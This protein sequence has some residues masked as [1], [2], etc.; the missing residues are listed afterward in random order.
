[1]SGEGVAF[2]PIQIFEYA[3]RGD[4]ASLREVL[5]PEEQPD[6]RWTTRSGDI[7]LKNKDN[8]T[9][10]HVACANGKEE[11]ANTLIQWGADFDA[12]NNIQ[13]TPLLLATM[14]NLTSTVQCLLAADADPNTQDTSG[15]CPL[16]CA[17]TK[18]NKE[19]VLAL[20]DNQVNLNA[21]NRFG[22][23]ALIEACGF[24][25][26]DIVAT[27]LESHADPNKLNLKD[28]S[29]LTKAFD[30]GHMDIVKTLMQTDIELDG[31]IK[32]GHF[33]KILS[34]IENEVVSLYWT[35]P[36]SGYTI[37]HYAAMCEH[38][39]V[40]SGM[41]MIL[42]KGFDPN[43]S[44]NDRKTVL[45][46]ALEHS[47]I[48][49][50][51]LL[52][53]HGAE[54][55]LQDKDGVM[56]MHLAASLGIMPVVQ[57]MVERG[58]DINLADDHGRSSI[59]YALQ[60]G[61]EEVALHLV[62]MGAAF[63]LPDE[64]GRVPLQL[65]MKAKLTRIVPML[66]DTGPDLNHQDSEGMS[67][68]HEAVQSGCIENVQAILVRLHSAPGE[69]PKLPYGLNCPN[70]EQITPLLTSVIAQNLEMVKLLLAH[71][72][73]AG[74]QDFVGN[75]AVHH[76]VQPSSSDILEALLECDSAV[77]Q[78]N[79]QNGNGTAPVHLACE[80]GNAEAIRVLLNHGADF[81]V[82]DYCGK[83]PIDYVLNSAAASIFKDWSKVQL[84]Y[85]V[86]V[87]HI[88]VPDTLDLQGLTDMA[89]KS[90][91]CEHAQFKLLGCSDGQLQELSEATMKAAVVAGG[92]VMSPDSQDSVVFID[93]DTMA[94]PAKVS[95]DLI[96]G[97]YLP[98]KRSWCWN[99]EP[100]S[101][102]AFDLDTHSRVNIKF[103]TDEKSFVAALQLHD[104]IGSQFGLRVI[105]KFLDASESLYAIVTEWGDYTLE[106]L[107]RTG[108]L[109]LPEI[110]VAV[111]SLAMLLDQYESLGLVE[112]FLCPSRLIRT[113]RDWKVVDFDYLK[114]AGQWMQVF[115]EDG[116]PLYSS[117]EMAAAWRTAIAGR[118]QR[119]LVTPNTPMWHLG[120][121][122]VELFN[123]A[124]CFDDSRNTA[125]EQ[126]ASIEEVQFGLPDQLAN[127]LIEGLL[128]K[129][130]LHRLTAAQT[131]K[132][133]FVTVPVT[134]QDTYPLLNGRGAMAVPGLP[135]A[136][137]TA[138]AAP[139]A[140][141]AQVDRN[142]Q[143][144]REQQQ[145]IA[146]LQ[147]RVTELQGAFKDATDKQLKAIKSLEVKVVPESETRSRTCTVS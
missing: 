88:C 52:L 116:G 97:R 115:V 91:Q 43:T 99:N 7:N 33:N 126:L 27:L 121:I 18:E 110:Q 2:K 130:Q 73:I 89:R 123:G 53:A 100:C 46:I 26:D 122:I 12:M 47:Q 81:Q 139:V 62:E 71:G 69:P 131:L 101:Q 61:N 146:Q 72:A 74:P 85:P 42:G 90:V 11:A 37:L 108:K 31:A 60:Q 143:I 102:L 23:T 82:K 83:A 118:E 6:G 92:K 117:P 142:N 3:S 144:H 113:G 58:A 32:Q 124:P 145:E 70:Q 120:L 103:F 22:N 98:D 96:D 127:E 34:L 51:E 29:A 79:T 40:K 86:S 128:V 1:M 107:L 76:A 44:T 134:M 84:I 21:V 16:H 59:L 15:S 66:L 65:A 133:P 41:A 10:L 94:C 95:Q 93:P 80:M 112:T 55:H 64:Q 20:V 135:P 129:E 111:R 136:V 147:H 25:Y 54:P 105:D 132:H 13:R 87:R 19:I 36:S 38:E 17:C 67:V 140:A 138:P 4:V 24:G 75:T 78:I 106:E 35:S 119:I 48:E 137:A 39:V 114:P 30:K 68:F 56:P 141:R 125:V 49:N 63:N 104:N 77:A 28:M 14:Q 9:L 8:D 57:M 45:H 109:I 5:S 50:A